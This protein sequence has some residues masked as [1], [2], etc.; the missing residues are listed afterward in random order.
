MTPFPIHPAA[1]QHVKL[2]LLDVDGVLTDGRL[3]YGPEGLL[4]KAFHVRDGMGI[5]LL[6]RAGIQ[7]GI[8]SGR[9]DPLVRRRAEELGI[10]AIILGEDS[11]G[12]A[13]TRLIDEREID[14]EAVAFLGDDVNDLPALSK[15]GVP[16]GV[17]DA[18]PDVLSFVRYVTRLRG[19]QGAVREVADAIMGVGETDDMDAPAGEVSA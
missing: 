3:Y 8:V 7:T 16:I 9:N 2:L 6:H 19:G 12:Q 15:V 1:V 13:V 4:T 18:H 10:T 11:K 5:T 14:R 17:A